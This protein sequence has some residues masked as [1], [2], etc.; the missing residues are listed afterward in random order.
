MTGGSD[1]MTPDALPTAHA[2]ALLTG[3]ATTPDPVALFDP[4]D[5]L[6]WCNLAFAEVFG[7]AVGVHPTWSELM[8]SAYHRRCGTV[9]DAPDF[10]AWLASAASRRGKEPFRAFEGDVHGGRWI[11]MTE[12]KLADG[13]LFCIAHDV[14]SLRVDER[15]LR[16]ARDLAQREARSDPLTGLGNRRHVMDALTMALVPPR[17][18]DSYIALV[19]LDRF[20]RINDHF[21]HQAGDLVL[22]DFARVLLA[23]IRRDDVVGRIGGEEF[24]VLLPGVGEA[25]AQAVAQRLLAATRA[26]VPLPQRPEFRYSCSIGL[27][28]IDGTSTLDELL[29]RADEALFAAKTAGRDRCVTQTCKAAPA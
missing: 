18:E 3:L 23:V 24:L 9:V 28:A 6:S 16:Q 27:L 21:G 4:A 5:R 14:T 12:L 26:S 11:S 29:H 10:E 2:A 19:D 7:V 17:R 8:R 15:A 1:D 20:K 13:S 25:A 22:R